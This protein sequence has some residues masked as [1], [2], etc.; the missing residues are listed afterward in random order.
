ME[1][2]FYR[3]SRKSVGHVCYHEGFEYFHCP[4]GCLYRANVY[5]PVQLSGYR[6]GAFECTPRKD[7]HTAYLSS[8]YGLN[9]SE[10]S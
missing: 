1:S 5:D 10:E 9:I 8:A 4:E 3:P 2:E 6:S 7:G